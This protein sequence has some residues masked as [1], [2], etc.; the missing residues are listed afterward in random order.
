MFPDSAVTTYPFSAVVKIFFKVPGGGDFACSGSLIKRGIV[1]TAGHCA[2]RGNGTTGPNRGF[3]QEIVVVPAYSKGAA[4][5]GQ[6]TV[7]NSL[8]QSD[9]VVDG[10]LG[11]VNRG[12]FALLVLESHHDGRFAGDDTG[13][14]GWQVNSLEDKQVLAAG[15]PAKHDN[16]TRMHF[17]VSET[18]L[19]TAEGTVLIVSDMQSGSSGSP[20]TLK[21]GRPSSSQDPTE[22]NRVVGVTSYGPSYGNE[23]YSGSSILSDK[24]VAMLQAACREYP[25]QC[26]QPTPLSHSIWA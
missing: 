9:W 3:H 10:W 6:H 25:A 21:F 19:A 17:V 18:S 15:Y 13:Y 23:T 2:H 7:I 16:G 1:L 12:D 4:P 11:A 20:W 24:F 5:F 26:G 22:W 8:V 14:L